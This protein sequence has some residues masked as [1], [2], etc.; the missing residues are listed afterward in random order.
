MTKENNMEQNFINKLIEQKYMY[1]PDLQTRDILNQNFREKFQELNYVNLS[2]AE[3][4]K[5]LDKIISADV[6]TTQYKKVETLK[7]HKKAL[8]Q[9]LFPSKEVE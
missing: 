7:E 4:G 2:D 5:P 8:M 3:F 9:Q 6:F 1:R